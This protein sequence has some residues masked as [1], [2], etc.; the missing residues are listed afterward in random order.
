MKCCGWCVNNLGEIYSPWNSNDDYYCP[1]G[2]SCGCVQCEGDTCETCMSWGAH[3]CNLMM[4]SE[5]GGICQSGGSTYLES[6][7]DNCPPDCDPD[8]Y[9]CW[10]M[11]PFGPCGSPPSGQCTDHQYYM[12]CCF[13]GCDDSPFPGGPYHCDAWGG[14]CDGSM[15]TSSHLSKARGRPRRRRN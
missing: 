6:Y 10:N 1:P 4:G 11:F 2:D 12:Y 9:S 15:S 3:D 13:Y 8:A 14:S 5:G 7:C